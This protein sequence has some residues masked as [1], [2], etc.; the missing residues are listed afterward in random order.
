MYYVQYGLRQRFLEMA[1]M[2]MRRYQLARKL[3]GKKASVTMTSVPL[4]TEHSKWD[5]Y[6]LALECHCGI[7]RS[8]REC[9]HVARP[10]SRAIDVLLFWIVNQP[11]YFHSGGN[12]LSHSTQELYNNAF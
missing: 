9:N 1:K 11:L 6:F 5:S 2:D 7:F 3:A 4:A 8:A 10:H 12:G